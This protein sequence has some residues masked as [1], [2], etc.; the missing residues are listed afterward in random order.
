M[1]D[2]VKLSRVETRLEELSYPVTRD[3]AATELAD[4]TVLMAD[5]E[6][7]L[8][9]VISELGSDSFSG[10]SE[11]YEELQGSLPMGAVGEPGQSDGDA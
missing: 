5:G 1:E 9:A 10:P 2:Q 7:N 3:D 4:V 8:G 11:L 6:A